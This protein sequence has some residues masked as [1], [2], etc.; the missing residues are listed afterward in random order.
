[1]S[2]FFCEHHPPPFPFAVLPD[3]PLGALFIDESEDIK[4]EEEEED[5]KLLALKFSSCVYI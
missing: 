4:E 1:L 2:G 5:S 3:V